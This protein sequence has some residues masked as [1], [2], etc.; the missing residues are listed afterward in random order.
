[1]N[2]RRQLRVDLI[3]KLLN[4]QDKAIVYFTRRDILGEEVGPTSSVWELPEVQKLLRKQSGGGGWEKAGKDSKIYPP[5][6]YNLVET[7]KRFR[8][9]VERY[10]LKKDHPAIAKAAEFLFSC[11]TEEGDIRGFIG[12]Q[13]ATYYTGY[14][15]SLLSKAGYE[16]DPRVKKGM[17][18]LLTVR[19]D[20]GGWTV[21]F[22]THEYDREMWL[23]LTSRYAEP[24]LPDRTKPFSH[25]ATD[26][27][28]RAFAA[29]SKY[30]NSKE[31]RAAGSLLKSRFFKPDAYTSY[32]SPK[33]WT[34][35]MFWWPNLLTSLESLA[36]L[37]FSKD[38]PDIKKALDW[39]IDNQQADGLWKLESDKVVKAKDMGERRWVGLRVGRVLKKLYM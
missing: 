19:Q 27:A 25:M 13:Y 38:D 34:R 29:H 26:M 12:N 6:Y 39:F 9:L 10:E 11:Q 36:S 31:A 37:G 21:P 32:Q 17:Q 30:K 14:I 8:L 22:V 24:V 20:D 18:W 15:L 5:Y 16:N 23:R 28:L 1:M 7:Y 33:Y 2:W 35:F 3:P 4:S